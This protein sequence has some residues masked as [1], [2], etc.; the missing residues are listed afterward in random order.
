MRPVFI[1]KLIPL[2]LIIYLPLQGAGSSERDKHVLYISSYNPSFP[3]F[4]QQVDGIRSVFNGKGVIMDIEFMDT[5]RL[6]EAEAARLFHPLLSAKIKRLPRYDAVI[7]ADD[8]ALRY[9]VKERDGIFKDIPVFFCGINDLDYI[10]RMEGR[11]GM[12]GA[13]EAVSMKDTLLLVKRLFPRRKTIAV[14]YDSTIPGKAD[15]SLFM[16][17]QE[18][19]GFF[20][21]DLSLA[22]LSFTELNRELDHLDAGC[23]ILLLA[24]YTDRTGK[25]RPFS[26]TFDEIVKH[27]KVPFFHLYEHGLGNGVLGG[28]IISH[29][30]QGRAAAQLVL[31]FFEGTPLSEIGIIRDSPNKYMFDYKELVRF[32]VPLSNLP[33]GSIIINKPNSFVMMHPFETF[34]VLMV[35]LFLMAVIGLLIYQRYRLASEVRRRTRELYK[36]NE[37]LR[38][39][40]YNSKQ[41]IWE[42][43][44]ATDQFINIGLE[45]RPDDERP[46]TTFKTGHDWYERL[47]PD[48]REKTQKVLVS[49]LKGDIPE[50][51]ASYRIKLNNGEYGW[52]ISRGRVVERDQDGRALMMSGITIDITHIKQVEAEVNSSKNMLQSVLDNIPMGVFWKSTDLVY[53]GCNY[54]FARSA[55][56]TSPEEIYGKRDSDLCW[57]E[58]SALHEK[59]D[60]EVIS[61]GKKV[62]FYEEEM[63]N[64][65]GVKVFFRKLKSPLRDSG[66]DVIGILGVQEDV[67]EA[68]RMREQ[69]IRMQKL[70]SVGILAGGLAHDFNNMLMGI[71]GSLAVLKLK[72]Q[73]EKKLHWISLAETSCSAAA[74]VTSRLITFA[75][76]GDPVMRDMDVSVLIKTVVEMDN[77]SAMTALNIELDISG[78]VPRIMG[79]ERQLGQ[80]L[81]NLLENAREAVGDSGGKI[82]ISCLAAGE[83]AAVKAGLKEGRHVQVAVH[84]TGRGIESENLG[85]IFDPYYSTKDMG[86]QK[87]Q[88]LGLT[89]CHSIIK[90]H[91][92]AIFAE[93][94]PASGTTI[95]FLLP[96]LD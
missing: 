37:Q 95:T 4:F 89:V 82:S 73:D 5:K 24:P 15:H 38:E 56:L 69:R 22:K 23:T 2:L 43:D 11:G 96:A 75:R 50:Y 1:K 79:D 83:G 63:V 32:G 59:V 77:A 20:I 57:S 60:R 18:G 72:E 74:E 12:R 93:S 30:E 62:G 10:K 78:E 85:K 21:R 58:L 86:T 81:R 9:A 88:G 28:K 92:G 52:V 35:M 39:A 80:V 45:D 66:G 49:H 71:A 76:G 19:M 13:I 47:H 64:A 16:R 7:V 14:I 87:G 6:P 29:Y 46:G 44:P 90:N 36:A 26:E 55:M 33:D 70:E 34:A 94:D 68:R 91:G 8:A 51:E 48:D 84:D 67:T 27:T 61:T 31:K 54:Q 25:T 3:T 65:A 17:E 53:T 40:L 41:V 42:W